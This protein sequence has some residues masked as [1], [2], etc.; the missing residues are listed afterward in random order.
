MS[1]DDD[2]EMIDESWTV[3]RG[4][5]DAMVAEMREIVDRARAEDGLPPQVILFGPRRPTARSLA[6]FIP[7][8]FAKDDEP[9]PYATA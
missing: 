3:S 2:P 8:P 9:P 7:N 6:E 5:L 1:G 4:E